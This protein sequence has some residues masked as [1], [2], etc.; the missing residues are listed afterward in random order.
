[1]GI[2]PLFFAHEMAM[3]RRSRFLSVQRLE[4]ERTLGGYGNP[5]VMSVRFDRQ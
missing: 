4:F 5:L 1:M 3:R 2:G